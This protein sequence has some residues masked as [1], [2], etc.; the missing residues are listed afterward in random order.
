MSSQL[1]ERRTFGAR[2]GSELSLTSAVRYDTVR[3]V[4]IYSEVNV[5]TNLAI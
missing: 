2:G 5:F 4:S 1:S 3:L